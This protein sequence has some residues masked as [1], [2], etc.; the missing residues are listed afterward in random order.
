VFIIFS[1]TQELLKGEGCKACGRDLSESF[2]AEI[3]GGVAK[4]ET[5]LFPV[6]C[7]CGG[8]TVVG[9]GTFHSHIDEAALKMRA[10]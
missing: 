3:S 9:A 6:L 5:V 2:L 7:L 4:G 1:M 10:V 8:I